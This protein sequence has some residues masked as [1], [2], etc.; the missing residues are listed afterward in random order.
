MAELTRRFAIPDFDSV[1]GTFF[2][3]HPDGRRE[4]INGLTAGVQADLWWAAMRKANIFWSTRPLSA[5]RET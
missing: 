2:V 1:K 3:I 5:I 4:D